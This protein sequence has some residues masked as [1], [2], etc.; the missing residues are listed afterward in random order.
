[1]RWSDG[2]EKLLRTLGKTSAD[3]GPLSIVT[4]LDSNGFDD[5][6]WCLRACDGIDKDARL[7]SVWCARQV[8]H[9]MD[10][11]RLINA[12]DVSE[13]YANGNATDAELKIAHDAAMDAAE[14]AAWAVAECAAWATVW[15][16]A[17][18][19][20]WAAAD[21]AAVGSAGGA[22]IKAA[23]AAAKTAQEA[24]FRRIFCDASSQ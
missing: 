17:W 18:D 10:D 2:W 20:A 4:I 1:M 23:R 5:A 8:Q 6:I 12:L 14:C 3:D 7:F 9:L 19:A 16:Q 15:P 24:E 13:R 22:S 11:G 21:C